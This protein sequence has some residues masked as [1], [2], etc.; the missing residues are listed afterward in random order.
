M[1]RKE[2]GRKE[3]RKEKKEKRKKKR[4]L[5]GKGKQNKERKGKKI[6]YEGFSPTCPARHYFKRGFGQHSK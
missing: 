3:S 2:M 5:G 1:R 4:I 6:S